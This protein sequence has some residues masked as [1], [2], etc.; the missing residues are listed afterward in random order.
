MSPIHS[1]LCPQAGPT[2]AFGLSAGQKPRPTRWGLEEAGGS[3]GGDPELEQGRQD[4]KG[5][6]FP[7]PARPPPPSFLRLQD[8]QAKV[9]TKLGMEV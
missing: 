9:F 1:A 7:G 3:Q 4:G 5:T 6:Q 2:R 8:I